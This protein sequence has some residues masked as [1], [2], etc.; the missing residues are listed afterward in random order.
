[1][2]AF[3]PDQTVVPVI[4]AVV[5]IGVPRGL[6]LGL[7]VSLA[8]ARGKAVQRSIRGNDGGALIQL[9]RDVAL[10]S[11]RVAEIASRGKVNSAATSCRG[12]FNGFVDCRRIKS[13]AIA[14]RA[15]GTYV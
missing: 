10:Q 3:A 6:W 8:G 12:G 9:D 2:K 11:N 1:M 15:E 7:I 14:C 4:V 5:L 13:C